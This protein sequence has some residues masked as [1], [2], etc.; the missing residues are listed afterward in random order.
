VAALR[1]YVFPSVVLSLPLGWVALP[2]V[3][4][5][6]VVWHIAAFFAALWI[7]CDAAVSVGF[8]TNGLGAPSAA[9]VGASG[10]FATTL[11]MFPALTACVAR[12][13]VDALISLAM[14]VAIRREARRA[15]E[16]CVQWIDDAGDVERDTA[17]W[18]ALLVLAT[19]FAT[20]GLV[21][22]LLMLFELDTGWMMA[23]VYAVASAVLGLLMARQGHRLP[24]LRLWPRNPGALAVG[25]LAGAV[26]AALSLGLLKLLVRLGWS[27]GEGA[28]WQP[29]GS[30]VYAM[31]VAV[32]VLA[33]LAEE[34]FFR[35]W[36]QQAIAAD[37]PE[38]RRHRAIVYG[39]LAFA[40]VHVGSLYVPQLVL[41]LIA[42]ALYVWSGGLLPGMVAHAVHNGL[43]LLLH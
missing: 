23:I 4:V 18:R 10:S 29:R 35:G 39:A 38:G 7:L 22:R 3:G 30:A 24:R 21:A 41:G 5:W 9:A 37:L 31:L 11:L 13:P 19:F 6:P 27:P 15:A 17:V 8:L 2:V 36:L 33:P 20:Q 28:E 26:S 25:G 16:R 43:A 1:R 12:T 42:G 32:V 14:L 34:S 40:A